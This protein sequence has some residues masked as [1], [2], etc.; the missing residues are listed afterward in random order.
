MIKVGSLSAKVLF[1]QH[2]LP[3]LLALLLQVPPLQIIDDSEVVEL[4]GTAFHWNP[5][6]VAPEV[7]F[8]RL[9]FPEDPDHQKGVVE[10][11]QVSEKDRV[12]LEDL[13]QLLLLDA[14]HSDALL[15]LQKIEI[16]EGFLM[17]FV[18]GKCIASVDLPVV[19]A[20]LEVISSEDLAPVATE[21]V[22]HE[23]EVVGSLDLVAMEG[24]E[25]VNSCQ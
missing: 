23:D 24:E 1:A 2:F 17:E 10:D 8:L 6:T 22:L 11:V 3:P 4:V 13:P 14:G 7:L 25:T 16:L 5:L 21:D 12:L 18:G 9:P 19:L 20:A 15:L